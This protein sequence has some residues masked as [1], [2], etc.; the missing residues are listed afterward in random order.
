MFLCLF[1]LLLVHPSPSDLSSRMYQ[2]S[3]LMFVYFRSLTPNSHL[4]CLSPLSLR[5]VLE[6][7]FFFLSLGCTWEFS[8]FYWMYFDWFGNTAC[9]HKCKIINTDSL[10]WARIPGFPFVVICTSVNYKKNVFLKP[11]YMPRCN[12]PP[13]LVAVLCVFCS[14]AIVCPKEG[15]QLLI[16]SDRYTRYQTPLRGLLAV[17]ISSCLPPKGALIAPLCRCYGFS[18]HLRG[19][20]VVFLSDVMWISVSSCSSLHVC[21]RHFMR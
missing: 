13:T 6:G 3:G 10:Y 18:F 11:K 4:Q 20:G 2:S 14:R 17:V 5:N 9:H 16:W 8:L 1:C 15:I 7:L 19:N 12:I 21:W